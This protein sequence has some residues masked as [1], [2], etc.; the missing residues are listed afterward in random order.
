MRYQLQDGVTAD[1]E[2][3]RSKETPGSCSRPAGQREVL[4]EWT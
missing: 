3:G 1:E 2:G 4:L